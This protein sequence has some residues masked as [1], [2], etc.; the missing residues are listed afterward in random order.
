MM[1]ESTFQSDLRGFQV[2]S[3]TKNWKPSIH[4]HVEFMREHRN[5]HDKFAVAGR[6]LILGTRNPLIVG[7]IATQISRYIWYV[8]HHGAKITEKVR[9]DKRK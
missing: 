2:Y 5:P 9:S 4:Q 3:I 8:R 1:V 6:V 7:H